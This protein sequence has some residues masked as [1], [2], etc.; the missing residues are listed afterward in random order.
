MSSGGRRFRRLLLNKNTS[1]PQPSRFTPSTETLMTSTTG[2]TKRSAFVF[3]SGF[4]HHLGSP[5][6]LWISFFQFVLSSTSSSVNHPLSISLLHESFHLAVEAVS[7][8]DQPVILIR[9]SGTDLQQ[10]WPRDEF[11]NHKC[12]FIPGDYTP[13]SHD[14]HDEQK[15][16]PGRQM[17]A[18]VRKLW[19]SIIVTSRSCDVTSLFRHLLYDTLFKKT[20]LRRQPL[21]AWIGSI[22][23]C[24]VLTV[25]GRNVLD[26][27][28]HITQAPKC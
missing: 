20:R 17:C 12:F 28:R 16:R 24:A 9:F 25:L 6:W 3:S 18:S 7:N 14:G 13:Y 10:I 27:I 15:A 1:W 19:R 5:E 23:F 22:E 11:K 2:S 4:S 8:N 21:T 26:E